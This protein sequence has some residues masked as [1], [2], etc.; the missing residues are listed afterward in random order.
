MTVEEDVVEVEQLISEV[1]I[2]LWQLKSRL[3]KCLAAAA[4]EQVSRLNAAVLRMEDMLEKIELEN[5]EMVE[6][7]RV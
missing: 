3:P 7:T 1:S 4:P 6:E 5:K 2:K